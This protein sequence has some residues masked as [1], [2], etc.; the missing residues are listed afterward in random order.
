VSLLVVA[1]Q[2]AR[3][4]CVGFFNSTEK[5]YKLEG[6]RL[7]STGET[8]AAGTELKFNGIG[9]FHNTYYLLRSRSDVIYDG[10]NVELTGGCDLP[11]R[12]VP[13]AK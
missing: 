1:P 4:D 6:D 13:R 10:Q 7:E 9:K 8:V 11:T 5:G 12:E 2:V 3:A